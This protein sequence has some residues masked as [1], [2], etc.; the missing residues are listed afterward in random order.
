MS[1]QCR[2]CRQKKPD[3][4]RPQSLPARPQSLPANWLRSASVAPRAGSALLGGSLRLTPLLAGRSETEAEAQ[5]VVAEGG[6][7]PEPIRG[8]GEVRRE[9]PGTTACDAGG[10]VRR[11]DR[12]TRCAGWVIPIPVR[13]PLPYVPVHIVKTPAV[14]RILTDIRRSLQTCTKAIV[15]VIGILCSQLV[16]ERK[17]RLRSPSAGILPLSLRRQLVRHPRRQ[18][19]RRPLRCSKLIAERR[20][21][22][23]VPRHCISTG[24]LRLP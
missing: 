18:A 19:P 2:Q 24:R 13:A 20:Y 5:G 23:R 10:A 22:V 17:S 15:G 14:R 8:T 16:A 1:R 4:K 6:L 11:T 3:K 7:V 9:E 21:A 12:I